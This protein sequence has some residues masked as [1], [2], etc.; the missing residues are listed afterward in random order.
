MSHSVKCAVVKK[1]TIAVTPSFHFFEHK[2][3]KKK[4]RFPI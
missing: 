4:S 2:E 1:E 3:I